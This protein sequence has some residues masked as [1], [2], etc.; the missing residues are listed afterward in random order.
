MSRN[1]ETRLDDALT[2]LATGATLDAE[3]ADVPEVA[4]LIIVAREL[5]ILAP[6]PQPRLAEGRRKFLNEAARMVQPPRVFERAMTPPARVFGF[7]VVLMLLVVG[8]W[9]VMETSTFVGNVPGAS[10]S[11]LT[12]SP[13]HF[14]TPTGTT[15][16]PMNLAPFAPTLVTHLNPP[17][18]KPVPIPLAAGD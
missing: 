2:Q 7:A 10:S 3:L 6:A 16:T 4:N 13:T 8:V 18:P 14:T 5:Q 17:Q 11:T 9:L 1:F 15:A 12:M